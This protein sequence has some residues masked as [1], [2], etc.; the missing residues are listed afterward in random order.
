MA[1]VQR[2]LKATITLTPV[3]GQAPSF[4]NSGSA[5]QVTIENLRMSAEVINAGGAS[6]GQLQ[7]S[8]FGLLQS[9]IN[10]LSTLGMK[11][12]FLPKNAIVLEA[13][14][15]QTGMGT[16]FTG[17]ILRAVANFNEQP[18]VALHLT[19]LSLTPQSV[20]PAKPSSF[21]GSAS[22]ATIMSGFATQLGLK[23]ENSGVNG[24]L[25]NAYFSG[26]LRDQAQACVDAAGISWNHGEKGILAIWPK[27]GSRGGPPTLISPQTGMKGYPI[28]S[29]LG[30]DVE[31]LFNSSIGLGSNVRIQSS[32]KPACGIFSVYGLSHSLACEL[33]NGQWF[34]R[35][36]CYTPKGKPSST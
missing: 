6:S 31:T 30:V 4:P 16:V 3:Y 2:K 23:F 5:D 36:R 26:S 32:L 34:S 19:A 25:S 11:R 18:D 28:Y 9:T 10:R 1:L 7:M 8:I 24:T 27:F 15:D 12:N 14:D 29:D 33:P 20:A 17:Y 21:P 13:G 22:V 35:V